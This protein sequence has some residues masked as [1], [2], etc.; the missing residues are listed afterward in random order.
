MNL[1]FVGIFAALMAT[2]FMDDSNPWTPDDMR[3][4]QCSGNLA[5]TSFP[6]KDIYYTATGSLHYVSIWNDNQ[7]REGLNVGRFLAE[8]RHLRFGVSLGISKPRLTGIKGWN[9]VEPGSMIEH[10]SGLTIHASGGLEPRVWVGWRLYTV[11]M[12][13]IGGK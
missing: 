6:A 8:D 4:I 7:K 9:R 12:L 2:G 13:V 11:K 10:S 3:N 5:A 1:F